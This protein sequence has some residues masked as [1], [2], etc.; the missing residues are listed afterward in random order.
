MQQQINFNAGPAALPPEVL[1]EASKAVRKYNNTGLSILELPHRGKDFLEIL[2][3]SKTLVRQL[4][5]IG[6]DYEVLWMQGGGRLQFCMIPM[7]FLS[8]RDSAGY[9]D[10]GHWA[11]SALESATHYGDVQVLAS[12]KE[13]NY[14][15]LPE[16]PPTIP[17][18]LSYLHYT[19]NNTI[20]GTQWHTAPKSD[21][22][23]IA[24]MSSDIFSAKRNYKNYAMF[25][26]AAQ[27]NLG[28][29]GT[30][31][32][33]IRKD[34]LERTTRDLPPMLSYK[35]H[36]K[37]HSILNTANV[38]GIY[39]SLLMLRWTADK[40]IGA[41][42]KENRQKAK[43]LYDA[44]DKSEVFTPHVKVK[45]DRS[46]MNVCFTAKTPK[47]EKDFLELCNENNIT[48]VKGHRSVGGF[49]VSLYNAVPLGSVQRLVELMNK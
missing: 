31:L 16:W 22:P 47:Q 49:R 28:A 10:S 26:A 30:T 18:Q 39:V 9:I 44:L 20:F 37:E 17:A 38:F 5:G 32:V 12:S 7:N 3:E 45:A 6:N 4:C 48:G 35:A 25:Y 24:D 23:L 41:I 15:R 34:L 33:V 40:G 19:T 11:E 21:V 1:F 14:D 13:S 8:E 46:L 27:K 29:A 43:L 36:V 2:D 42:E